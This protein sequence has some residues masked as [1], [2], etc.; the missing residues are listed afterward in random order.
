MKNAT[1][2]GLLLCAAC[3]GS[4]SGSNATISITSPAASASVALGSDSQ[5]TVTMIYAVTSFDVKAPGSCG[6]EANCGHVHILID[7]NACNGSDIYNDSSYAVPDALAFFAKCA[8]PTG[9]HT[10]T[11]ELHDDVHNPVKDKNGNQ[12][13]T[14][15]SFTTH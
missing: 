5:K 13:Q 11:L 4:S 15:V 3:G 6:S 7:G 9:S 12:V 2:L 10:V 8:T 1:L 14:S